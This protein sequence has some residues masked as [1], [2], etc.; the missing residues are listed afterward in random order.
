MSSLN[1][2]KNGK[3]IKISPVLFNF[4]YCLSWKKNT[5]NS[6]AEKE[7]TAGEIWNIST[8]GMLVNNIDQFNGTSS[9][10]QTYC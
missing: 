8:A 9:F 5:F 3:I 4:A 7:E 10:K 2:E 1:Y 6:D